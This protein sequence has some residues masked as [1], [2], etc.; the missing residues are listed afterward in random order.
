M[1]WFKKLKKKF[2]PKFKG[3]EYVFEYRYEY[4]EHDVYKRLR[5][6]IKKAPISSF[7][8]EEMRFLIK[9]DNLILKEIDDLLEELDEGKEE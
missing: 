4:T 3:E 2:E 1:N 8:D 6:A 5:T 9:L 7:H